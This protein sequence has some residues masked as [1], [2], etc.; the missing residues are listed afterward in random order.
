MGDNWSKETRSR[1]MS[2]IRSSGNK[3]TELRLIQ[4]FREYRISGWRRNQELTGKPDFVFRGPR[5]A[6]FV[7][8]C[9]WHGCPR[10]FRRPA[11][12]QDYWDAKIARNRKRDR[13]VGRDLRRQGWIVL[14][15]WQHQLAWPA[16]T[17]GRVGRALRRNQDRTKDSGGQRVCSEA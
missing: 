11:S 12:N 4:I 14:R 1:V 2:H 3:G 13:A 15:I 9:F 10:C 17:A 5:V 8:G 6:V 7:D 16:Q